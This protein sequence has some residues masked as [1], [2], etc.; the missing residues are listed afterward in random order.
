MRKISRKGLD[1]DPPNHE[2]AVVRLC[3]VD[4]GAN[5]EKV[6]ES[7]MSWVNKDHSVFERIHDE[8]RPWVKPKLPTIVCR[9]CTYHML[10]VW[11]ERL[12]VYVVD[13]SYYAESFLEADYITQD[14]FCVQNGALWILEPDMVTLREI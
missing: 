9:F 8:D 6:L 3:T 5:G 4:A 2:P 14:S 13:H 7:D 10:P 11:N 1:N 12:R